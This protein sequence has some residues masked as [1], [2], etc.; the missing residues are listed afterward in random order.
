MLEGAAMPRPRNIVLLVADSLRYDSVHR[1]GEHGLPFLASH[2]ASF[3]QARS[4]GCWTLPGT[5]SI[6]TG[7]LPHEHGADARSRWVRDDV[8]TLA[9]RLRDAG[10]HTRQISAN[11]ATS[12]IFGLDRGFEDFDRIWRTVPPTYRRLHQALLLVGKPRLRR[13]LLSPEY[14][15]GQLAEDLDASKVW[16]QDTWDAVFDAA[17]AALAAQQQRPSFLFLNLMETHFP[18]HVGPQFETLAK[19]PFGWLQEVWGLFH[20]VNQT[21]VV[22]GEQ[23]IGPDLMLRLRERQRVA[24]L[25][26]APVVDAFCREMAEQG[27]LV[28]FCSDHGENFGEQGW[29]YH[30]ANVTDAGNRVPLWWVH[31]DGD[32]AGRRIDTPVSTRD[33]YATLLRE[34]GLDAPG[35]H[36]LREPERSVPIIEAAW[37]DNNGRTLPR[38]Q[39]DQICFLDEGTRWRLRGGEWSSA[40]PATTGE[41]PPF[42]SLPA[43]FDP[44]E[45]GV[46]SNDRRQSLRRVVGEYTLTSSRSEA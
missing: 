5:A 24:W 30:F 46:L 27:N 3:S 19:G 31:P 39:H 15:S 26:L 44:F 2:G 18:Y 23:P 36:L 29:A 40:P 6:F 33:L 32:H 22:R 13:K 4:A 10:W 14:I 34:A 20:L 1:D 17:R 9:G 45:A 7:L 25:R 35:P 21:W 11:V 43:G 37:Y 42:V 41:E 28:V 16:L 12:E 8:P 38:F